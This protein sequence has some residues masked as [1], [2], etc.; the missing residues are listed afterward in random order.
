ML[1]R[2]GRHG[3]AL[4]V[5][6]HVIAVDRRRG[7]VGDLVVVKA[8]SPAARQPREERGEEAGSSSMEPDAK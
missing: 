5:L 4:D 3:R 7:A 6:I 1:G 8:G 2:R